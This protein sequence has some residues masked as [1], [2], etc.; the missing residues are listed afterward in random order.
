MGCHDF[1]QGIFPTQVSNPVL[2]HF[3][4]IL[5]HL[6]HQGSPRILE[7]VAN[8]FSRGSSDPGI[9]LGSPAL[10]ADSLSAE[11]TGKPMLALIQPLFSP[12]IQP[13]YVCLSSFLLN[14]TLKM[15]AFW[16]LDVYPSKTTFPNT[17]FL[18]EHPSFQKECHRTMTSRTTRTCSGV[19]QSQP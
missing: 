3:R 13:M 14:Y 9:E 12:P 7:W 4:Q 2:L 19:T 6:S 1:P 11:R 18:W 17:P 5:Y 15:I 8:P 16:L 10:Q